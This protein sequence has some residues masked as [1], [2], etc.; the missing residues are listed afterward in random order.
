MKHVLLYPA[1]HT[2]VII[3]IRNSQPDAFEQES[4]V[5]VEQLHT[6][7]STQPRDKQYSKL[8]RVTGEEYV[9]ALQYLLHI[10]RQGSD[11]RGGKGTESGS[12]S[13]AA[14]CILATFF[15]EFKELKG[16]FVKPA[17]TAK[18][19]HYFFIQGEIIL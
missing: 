5:K 6:S 7:T 18:S 15:R 16:I 8:A 10:H 12:D 2:R 17:P 9:R 14:D 11:P 1:V 3:R 19:E 4:L 13:D